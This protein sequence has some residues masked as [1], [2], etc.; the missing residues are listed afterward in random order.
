MTETWKQSVENGLIVGV[1]FIDFQKAFD[2]VSHEILLYKLQAAG[3]SGNLH[4][5]IMNYLKDRT[6][7]A[8]IN[9]E[10]S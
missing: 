2:T 8:E 3:I 7:Y 6:Q 4:A 1:V 10:C 5:L 9:G